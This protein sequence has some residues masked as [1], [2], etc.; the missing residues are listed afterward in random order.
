M[1]RDK[2]GKF[3]TLVSN[4]IYEHGK[5]AITVIM[6]L[7]ANDANSTLEKHV[8]LMKEGMPTKKTKKY[9]SIEVVVDILTY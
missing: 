1:P 4:H 7:T 5:L 8:F 9:K 6:G 3:T 2:P